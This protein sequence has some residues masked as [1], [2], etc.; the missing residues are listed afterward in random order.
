MDMNAAC[1]SAPWSIGACRKQ[2]IT[3]SAC[4][5]FLLGWAETRDS[6]GVPARIRIDDRDFARRRRARCGA[7]TRP[8]L[9]DAALARPGGACADRALDELRQLPARARRSA[10]PPAAPLARRA[11]R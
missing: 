9:P 3:I 10:Q 7:A 8:S 6:S 4:P 11:R 1:I 5:R 2:S